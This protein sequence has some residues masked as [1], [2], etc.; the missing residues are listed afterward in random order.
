MSLS[1]NR[2]QSQ[3]VNGS[4][5]VERSSRAPEDLKSNSP[6][7][8]QTY[9]GYNIQESQQSQQSQG[10]SNALEKILGQDPNVYVRDHMDVY[11]NLVNKWTDCTMDEWIAGANGSFSYLKSLAIMFFTHTT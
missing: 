3:S 2:R 11:E 1:L 4:P 9:E 7:K 10:E 6:T 5:F 8:L